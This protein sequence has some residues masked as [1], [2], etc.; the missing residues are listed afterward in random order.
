APGLVLSQDPHPNVK[1][2]E[3]KFVTLVVSQ[4][5]APAPVPDLA[6]LTQEEA[7]AGLEGVGLGLGEVSTQ[8][9]EEVEAGRVIDWE[10]KDGRKRGDSVALTVSQGPRPRTLP[11]LTEKTYDQAAQILRDMGLNPV[12]DS[13]YDNDVPEGRII[14]TRPAVGLTVERGATVTI[15]LSKGR[16]AV[17]NLDGMTEAQ[18]RAALEAVG[19]RLGSVFGLPGGKVFRQ[20]EAAGARVVIGTAVSI[21]VI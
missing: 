6:N 19:L 21:F 14:G 1:L 20:T 13:R 7:K 15:V 11:D 9:S 4:G 18:S 17:P 3:G 8:Y 5:P 16:P 10:P 12:Q 2:K